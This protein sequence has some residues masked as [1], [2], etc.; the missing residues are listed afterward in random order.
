[1]T[2]TI[3]Q[4]AEVYGLS[5]HT[6]R[7]WEDEGLI[8]PVARDESGRRRFTDTDLAWIRYASC[9]RGMG[10]GVRDIAEYVSVANTEGGRESQMRLLREHLEAMHKQREELTYFISIAEEKLG[11][12]Q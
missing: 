2:K 3:G 10:M 6:L 1:M 4:A 7:Y 5:T 12:L 11:S 8:P 9:L